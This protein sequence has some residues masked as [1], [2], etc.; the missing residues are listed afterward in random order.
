MEFTGE[1]PS[2]EWIDH[3]IKNRRQQDERRERRR[4]SE[5]DLQE[6]R[7]ELIKRH[8]LKEKRS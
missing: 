3:L 7:R 4:Y 6:Y 5:E 2:I 1:K 8:G